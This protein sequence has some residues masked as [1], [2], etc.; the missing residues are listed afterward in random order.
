M[1]Y[2]LDFWLVI[3]CLATLVLNGKGGKVSVAKAR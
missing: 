2:D 1:S 3:D